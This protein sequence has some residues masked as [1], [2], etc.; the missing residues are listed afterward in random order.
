MK[1]CVCRWKTPTFIN[2]ASSNIR[3]V[4]YDRDNADVYDTSNWIPERK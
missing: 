1:D 2:N 3:L 4:N